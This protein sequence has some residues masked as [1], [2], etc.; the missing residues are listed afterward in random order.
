LRK[1]KEKMKEEVARVLLK[2]NPFEKR[3]RNK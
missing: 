3:G 1:K 2:D